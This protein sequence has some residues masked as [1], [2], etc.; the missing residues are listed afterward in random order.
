MTGPVVVEVPAGR[1]GPEHIGR[2]VHVDLDKPVSGRLEAI[3]TPKS[4]VRT[5]T[6]GG[7]RYRNVSSACPVW[8]V[9]EEEKA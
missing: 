8:V 9:I 1:L 3:D 5:L 2:M 7:H 6:L 4:S